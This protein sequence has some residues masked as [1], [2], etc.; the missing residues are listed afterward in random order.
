[1]LRRILLVVAFVILCWVAIAIIRSI[2]E[3]SAS[4]GPERA[5]RE[6]NVP[7]SSDFVGCGDGLWRH[8]YNP[9]RLTIRRACVTVT[10][11]LVDPTASRT[12]PA[13]DGVRHEADGDTHGW[14]RVDSAFAGL[15]ND[16]NRLDEDGNLVFELVCHYTVKQLDARPACEAFHDTT[17]IPPSGAHVAITGTLVMDDNHARWNEIHPVSRIEVL[18][19]Q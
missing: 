5:A 4:A 13:R 15:I 19:P 12:H 11:I 17:E 7:G 8:V 3:R 16:G 14:L 1:M 10:G 6:L 18:P 9:Q 2:A